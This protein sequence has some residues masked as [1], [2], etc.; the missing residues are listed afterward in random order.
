MEDF[1]C[2][3][4]SVGEIKRSLEEINEILEN[5]RRRMFGLSC[6][7]GMEENWAGESQK[8]ALAFL[9]LTREYQDAL[10]VP[11]VDAAAALQKY[12][13]ADS[14]FYEGWTEYQDIKS[15]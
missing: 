11:I 14:T 10:S 2:V 7:M 9:S 3:T 5:V 15:I 6:M 8:A 4:G 12:L 1:K 13:E